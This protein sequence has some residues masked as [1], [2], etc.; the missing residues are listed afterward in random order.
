M[1]FLQFRS[2]F[3][4]AFLRLLNPLEKGHGDAL[5][6]GWMFF[7]YNSSGHRRPP[8][9]SEPARESVVSDTIDIE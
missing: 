1:V 5:Q 6:R 4:Q 3:L 7:F 8:C 2:G 9:G